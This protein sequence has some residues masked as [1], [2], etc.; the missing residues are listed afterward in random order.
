MTRMLLASILVMTSAVGTS[1]CAKSQATP[2]SSAAYAPGAPEHQEMRSGMMGMSNGEC[3]AA[4][5]GTTVR[6]AETSDGMTMTFTTTGD[7]SE[8]R[9]RVHSMADRMNAHSSAAMAMHDMMTGGADGGSPAT[10]GGGMGAHAM[11]GMAAGKGGH[12]M[13]GS[14]GMMGDMMPPVRAQAEDVEGGARLRVAPA[15]PSRLSE[16][17]EHMQRHA[18]MMNEGQGCPMTGATMGGGPK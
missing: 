10:V 6:V 2:A 16:L 3:P 14:D 5:P 11:P 12:G 4:L 9:K 17:R 1:A 18:G 7:V 13:M 15:D 8:L